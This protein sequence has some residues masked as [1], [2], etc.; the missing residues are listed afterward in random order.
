MKSIISTVFVFLGLFLGQAQVGIGT[1]TP[2]LTSMLEIKSDTAGVLIPRMTLTL[3]DA[4]TTPADGLQIYNTTNNTLDIYSNSSW[5]S[6][7][8]SPDSNLV[9][10]YSLSDLPTPVSGAINLDETKMYVFSGAVDITPNYININGAGLRGTDPQKDRVISAVSGA[11]LRSNN[12][13]V[14]IKELAVVPASTATQA[15]DFTGGPSNFCNIFSGSSVVGD[16]TSLGVGTIS[17]FNAIT[18]LQNY[19]NTAN[20]VKIGGTVGKFTSGYNF[21]VDINN[22]AGIELLPGLDANDI[23]IANNYFIYTGKIGL[24]VNSTADVDRGRL[25]TNMFRGVGTPLDG[26]TSAEIG[27]SM[28]QNTDIPDSKA[29]GFVYF[30]GNTTP[31]EF[32]NTTDFVKVAGATTA[33]FEQR[34]TASNNRLTYEGRRPIVANI[35]ATINA[36]SPANGSSYTI[37]ISKNGGAPTQIINTLSDIGNNNKFQLSINT[38]ISLDS[39]DLNPNDYIEVFIRSN[40]G[41]TDLIVDGLQFNAT[42]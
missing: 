24:K 9:Y 33:A 39:N 7:A 27:W 1:T 13:D 37:G 3:R 25:T 19:W 18:I 32:T 30:N 14:Y 6:F 26:I 34:Y 5:K 15:Y 29:I 40:A 22:G 4:I 12:T 35:I 11:V 21:I 28:L 42:N 8:Y 41:T 2:D 38:E 23:D 31:T 16:G 17:G 36:T 10:V 20:G